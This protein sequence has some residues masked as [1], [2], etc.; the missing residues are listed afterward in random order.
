MPN[1]SS[2]LARELSKLIE[3]LP[4]MIEDAV[5]CCKFR[6]VDLGD[7]TEESKR[8]AIRAHRGQIALVQEAHTAPDFI[9]GR[10]EY[11]PAYKRVYSIVTGKEKQ[12]KWYLD[13]T[14][15]LV[16]YDFRHN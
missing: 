5:L 7:R 16:L 11:D 13:L 1:K 15:L 9:A 6:Q 8:K 12:R 14:S 4:G 2:R 10:L 3:K